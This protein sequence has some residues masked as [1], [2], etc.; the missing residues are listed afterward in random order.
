M[1]QE[2]GRRSFRNR[3]SLEVS[4]LEYITSGHSGQAELVE[5]NVQCARVGTRG[6]EI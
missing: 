1:Q 3:D 5:V 6:G 2:A 4:Q